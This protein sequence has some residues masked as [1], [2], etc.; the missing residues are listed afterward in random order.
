MAGAEP[1]GANLE[2]DGGIVANDLIHISISVYS[3]TSRG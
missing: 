1:Q 2:A 3:Y